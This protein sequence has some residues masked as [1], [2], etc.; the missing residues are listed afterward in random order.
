MPLFPIVSRPLFPLLPAFVALLFVASLM[1][2]GGCCAACAALGPWAAGEP[3]PAPAAF[4]LCMHKRQ[5]QRKQ[6]Q[7]G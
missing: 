2:S 1:S 3:S 4:P 7:R 6:K 5:A